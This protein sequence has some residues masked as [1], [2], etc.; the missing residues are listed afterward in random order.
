MPHRAVG[1]LAALVLAGF[2]IFGPAEAQQNSAPPKPYKKVAVTPPAHT[3]DPAFEAF[4]KQLADAAARKDRAALGA[5]VAP[6]GF[7]WERESGNGADDQKSGLDNL[8]A[9]VGLDAKDDSGWQL[10]ADYASETA[11]SPVI[12]RPEIICGPG[13]PNFNDDD[14]IELVTVTATNPFDWGYPVRDGI[15][16]RETAAANAKVVEQLG[17]HLVLVVADESAAPENTDMLRIATPSGRFA[18]MPAN[19]LSPLGLD[20]LCYATLDGGWKIVGYVG[21]GPPQ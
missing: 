1:P 7:F 10:L 3:A 16:V 21:E 14:F 8:A 18:F 5:L 12:D 2:L 20:Q 17:M 9:A 11:T 6:K 4:R 13:N 15:E 19:L